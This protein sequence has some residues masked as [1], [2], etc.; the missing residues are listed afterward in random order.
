MLTFG[1]VHVSFLGLLT[2]FYIVSHFHSITR[3][4]HTTAESSSYNQDFTHNSCNYWNF[5]HPSL[6][7]QEAAYKEDKAHI[8]YLLEHPLMR[9]VACLPLA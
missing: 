8:T 5:N 9:C 7:Q 1:G 2:N 6:P 3:S 4:T